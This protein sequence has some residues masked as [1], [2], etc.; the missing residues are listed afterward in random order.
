MPVAVSYA[1]VY[2]EEISSG[3]RTL[4]NVATSIPAFVGY[5]ARGL[6]NRAK[7]LFS[8]A[9][10]E[11]SFGG[12]TSDSELSYAVK[13]FFD[14]G[15]GEAYVVRVPRSADETIAAA[16]RSAAAVITLFD[17]VDGAQKRALKFTALS[18]GAWANNVVIDVD[19]DDVP[20]NKSFNL[21]ITDLAIGES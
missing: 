7:R 12:L 18:K 3:V 4:S 10:F 21:T 8:F 13:H 17:A 19:Y 2:I 9:D 5:T 16:D 14:N 15:G 1:G 6:D 11:R 20:D